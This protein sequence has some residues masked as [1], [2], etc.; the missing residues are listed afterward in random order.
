MPIKIIINFLLVA[1]G[2]ALGSMVRY[3]S[4]LLLTR[5]GSLMP[6]GTLLANIVGSL[7]IGF[8]MELSTIKAGLPPEMRM[9]LAA[10]FCGGLTTL[11]SMVFETNGFLRERELLLGLGYGLLTLILAFIALWAGLFLCRLVFVRN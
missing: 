8:I 10:G 1:G 7:L 3:A 2:G 5:E 6:W 9:F 11:S 4:S